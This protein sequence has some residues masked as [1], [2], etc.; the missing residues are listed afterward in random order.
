MK[1]F[2]FS[3]TDIIGG[4][5]RFFQP[6]FRFI[7]RR[8]WHL[9]YHCGVDLQHES[10]RVEYYVFLRRS[11]VRHVYLEEGRL[12]RGPFPFIL[13]YTQRICVQA[14]VSFLHVLNRGWFVECFNTFNM[15]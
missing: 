2:L 1:V 13:N 9:F 7:F 11:A 15:C 3:F 4:G 12:L 5:D 8:E 10:V 14:G 6:Y